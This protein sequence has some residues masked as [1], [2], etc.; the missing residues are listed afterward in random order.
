MK[1]PETRRRVPGAKYAALFLHGIAGTPNQFRILLPLEELV[2][3]DWSVYN[4][5][6]PGHGG[7]VRDF[8]RSNIAQWRAHAR[9]AFLELAETHEKILIVGHSMGTLFALQLAVEFPEKAARLFLMNVP[10]RPWV[11][12]FCAKNCLR[13]AFGRIREDHPLEA[14]FQIACGAEPSPLVWRYLSWIPRVL[15]L[16][17]EIHKTEKIMGKLSVPCVAFQSKRDD[18]VSNFSAPVLR[19]SGVMEV[20]ELENSTHF[21]YNPEDLDTLRAAFLN[22][23]SACNGFT[24]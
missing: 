15:E 11:R 17:G 1:H 9:E 2:P 14:S 10:M 6:Y 20:H 16:F 21:F 13:L 18:L 4:L 19:K 22:Q 5:R 7:D 3:P 12:L 8:G 23:I 24:G